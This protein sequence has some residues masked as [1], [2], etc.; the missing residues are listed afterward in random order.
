MIPREFAFDMVVTTYHLSVRP[1]A[2]D[3][4][5]QNQAMDGVS[6]LVRID[7]LEIRHVPHRR[8]L[9]QDPV[10]AEEP[11]SLTGEVRGHVDI[12]SLG[13]RHLLRRHLAGV[14]QPTELVTEELRLRDLR[15]HLR[16][17]SERSPVVS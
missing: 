16:S 1:I 12:V 9:D 2:R 5:A 15:Q 8:V 13:H 3:R 7:G 4:L 10:A 6:A 11:P 17:S 14:L